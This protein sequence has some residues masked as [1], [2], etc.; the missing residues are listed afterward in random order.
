[1]GLLDPILGG[2]D[3]TTIQ[4]NEFNSTID[5]LAQDAVAGLQDLSVPTYFTGDTV[6]AQS[7]DTLAGITSLT[8]AAD[9][10]AGISTAANTGFDFV[11]NDLL[12]PATNTALQA[13]MNSAINPIFDRLENQTLPGIGGSA[14]QAGQF[15]GTAQTNL[16][17]DALTDATRNAGDITSGI[18]SNAYNTSL[19]NYTQTLLN[20]GVFQDL[21]G[22]PGQTLLATGGITDAYNQSL[23]NA[24]IDRYNFGETADLDYWTQ[25]MNIVNGVP[26][27]TAQAQEGGDTNLLNAGLS[28]ALTYNLL[29]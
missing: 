14:I 26:M 16:T 7:A 25:I 1:M 17:R 19:D 6:A 27:D 4:S 18:A 8:G 10:Q 15:G 12:D 20:S 5:P 11:L 22:Q 2:G 9:T 29:T 28:G 24:D 21:A 13:Y 3:T 23:I